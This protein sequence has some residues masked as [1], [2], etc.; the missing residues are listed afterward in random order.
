MTLSNRG[1]KMDT[2]LIATANHKPNPESIV[3]DDGIAALR[4]RLL[5]LDVWPD[6]ADQFLALMSHSRW[7]NL[8]LAESDSQWLPKVVEDCFNQ[9]D[10]GAT[11]PAFFQK[12]LLC[13]ELRRVFMD[14]LDRRMNAA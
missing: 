2:V 14:A 10:I 6:A 5:S 3:N 9:V 8:P 13:S 4:Q 12:L 1:M 11:Y 7:Q